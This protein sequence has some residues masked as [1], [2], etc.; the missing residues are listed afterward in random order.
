MSCIFAWHE[1]H[2]RIPRYNFDAYQF[3]LAGIISQ[4]YVLIRPCRVCVSEKSERHFSQGRSDI[5]CAAPLVIRYD[6]DYMC[7]VTPLKL[8]QEE[9][10]HITQ[11][12]SAMK[13]RYIL[14]TL[15]ALIIFNH[16]FNPRFLRKNGDCRDQCEPNVFQNTMCSARNC[17]VTVMFLVCDT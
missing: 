1:V 13:A 17:K 3:M 8:R 6:F 7:R 11:I 16:L 4:Q 5:G 14:K 10:P 12:D 9:K 2:P 15:S